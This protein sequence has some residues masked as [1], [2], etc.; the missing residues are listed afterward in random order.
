MVGKNKKYCHP[1][2]EA[3]VTGDLMCPNFN[4]KPRKREI[5]MW[6]VKSLKE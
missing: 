5:T 2:L 3:G 1:S 4:P 6:S